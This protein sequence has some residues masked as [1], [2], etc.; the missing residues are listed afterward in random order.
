[1]S[2]NMR[3]LLQRE[4]EI[5]AKQPIHKGLVNVVVDETNICAVDG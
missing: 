4:M 3:L 5:L 1:M 2:W